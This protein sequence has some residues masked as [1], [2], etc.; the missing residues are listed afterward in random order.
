MTIQRLILC[1]AVFLVLSPPVAADSAS[2]TLT[3]Q[4][5]LKYGDDAGDVTDHYLSG[6]RDGIVLYD[7]YAAKYLHSEE[8][9][10]TPKEFD[11]STPGFKALLDKQIAAGAAGGKP[12]PQDIPLQVVAIYALVK[13]FPCK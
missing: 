11:L 3:L 5:Y 12:W 13:T 1:L 7:A 6:L 8:H 4:D 9:I 2:G 10:C